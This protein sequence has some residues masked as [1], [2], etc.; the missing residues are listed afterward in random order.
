MPQT[1][2]D[3]QSPALLPEG[4]EGCDYVLNGSSCWVTVG[5]ISLWIRRDGMDGVIVEAYHVGEEMEP[6]LESMEVEAP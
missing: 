3:I 4:D 6:P 5:D 1:I 2:C